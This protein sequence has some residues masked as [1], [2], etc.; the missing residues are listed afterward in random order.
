MKVFAI[1]IG[2]LILMLLVVGIIHAIGLLKQRK[3]RQKEF[4]NSQKRYA[5]QYSPESAPM[6][7]SSSRIMKRVKSSNS[8]SNH[9]DPTLSVNAA[10]ASTGS[11]YSG[12][13]GSSLS[14]SCSSSSDSSSCSSSCD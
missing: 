9:Y 11:G 5:K 7:K 4:D 1:V 14:S 12:C 2:V 6:L 10:I 3:Q 8:S 13:S